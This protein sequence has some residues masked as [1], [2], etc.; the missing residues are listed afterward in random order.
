MPIVDVS[1]KITIITGKYQKK[2]TFEE[3][4]KLWSFEQIFQALFLLMQ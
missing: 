4:H 1:L 2:H 3:T